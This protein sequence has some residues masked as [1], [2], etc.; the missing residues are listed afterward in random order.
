MIIK[1][2]VQL[3]GREF[4]IETGRMAK[5]AHGSAYVSYAETGV[6]STAVASFEP[7]GKQD[8]VPLTVE[9]QERFYSAGRIPG[10][11]FKREGR[12]S[13]KEVLSS[14][15]IDRP[16]RPLI[17]KGFN[18]EMQVIS[19]V[20]SADQ[21]NDPDIIALTAASAALMFSDIPF[22]GPIAAVE[23]GR[24]KGELIL[25]PTV[26]QLL[27]SDM[28]III[29][30]SKDAVV[31]VEGGAKNVSEEEIQKA[32]FYGHRMMQ[33]IIELQESIAKEL[34]ITKRK[35]SD[36]LI[37]NEL[38]D[39]VK[40][41]YS[42]AF[43]DVLTTR[44][45]QERQT[46]ARELFE[47]AMKELT[48]GEKYEPEEI[49]IALE[50]LQA[51]MAR[52]M[53]TK[54]QKRID[55]RSLGEVRPITCEVGFLPRTHGSA[56]FTRGET[57]ALVVTTMGTFDDVQFIDEIGGENERR[58]ML[59]YNFP[60]F[61]VGEVKQMR[62][63]GRREIGHG[64]LA[65][66]AISSIIPGEDDFPYTIRI[67]SDILES[68]GSSSMATVCGATLS[69]MDAGVPI[70]APVAGVAMGLI[71]DKDN[72][73]ILTDILGDEDHLGDM[74]F[75]V[76]GTKDGVTS[77]QMDIKIA[78]VTEQ[79]MSD[80]LK[81][82]KK[83]RL[84]ILDIMLQTI[85]VS[86]ADISE[87]APRI[88]NMTIKNSRIKDLI[89]PGG[90]NIKNIVEKTGVKID[91]DDSGKVRIASGDTALMTKAIEMVKSLTR[92]AV[93]GEIYTGKVKKIMDFGAFVEIFPGTE[94]LVHISQLDEHRV[95]RV[96]DIVKEGDEIP[97]KVLDIDREGKIRLSR[98]EALRDNTHKQ[99]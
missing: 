44:I 19:F 39:L 27:E 9:Y 10:G 67:V 83:A 93:I 62:G 41:N 15:L 97:V 13:E 52:G 16:I 63:P 50:K 91:V 98:K 57:Q 14:R 32:I 59:H 43:T 70:K 56:L 4:T 42:A 90:K 30:G 48:L 49:E 47:K 86:R 22:A 80:A 24:I 82:A 23:V 73:F 36:S 25:N 84:H 74:D 68:N 11:Y 69:L 99:V 71:K 17:P 7:V 77:I 60:P 61:S 38:Y 66:R 55:G 40:N 85:P 37:S 65:G 21:K 88:V 96:E 26:D 64:A 18:Y 81:Q 3:G 33:P 54:E 87:Y 72:Y 46:K 20:I 6:L 76:A 2:S 8:F 58:F 35:Y 34:N 92:D 51:E 94:G 53:I 28:D 31:M 75:K 79:I 78:G 1:K 95:N 5:Q 29:A 45:K 89:G 12:P